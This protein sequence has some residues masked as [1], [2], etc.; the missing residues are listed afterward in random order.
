MLNNTVSMT[1][2]QLARSMEVFAVVAPIALLSAC[3]SEPATQPPPSEVVAPTPAPMPTPAP[4]PTPPPAR[5]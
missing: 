2:Y 1:R 3:S 4:A 5:G